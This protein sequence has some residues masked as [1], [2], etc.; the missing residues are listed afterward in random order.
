MPE[1]VPPLQPGHLLVPFAGASDET[2]ASVAQRIA[3]PHLAALLD[4]M[5]LQ[6][7]DRGDAFSL[8]LPHERALAAS[9]GIDRAHAPLADG[10]IPWAARTADRTGVPCAWFTPCHFQA[11]MDQVML[12]PPEA[13]AL[14]DAHARALFDALLPYAREDGITLVYEHATRWRAEGEAL[15]DLPCASLD[16]VAHRRIDAWLPPPSRSPLLTRLQNEA[17]MLF[18]THPVHDERTAQGL[19]GINGFWISGCGVWHGE[20]VP[21]EAAPAVDDRLRAPALRGD[22]KAWEQAWLALDAGPVQTLLTRARGG[23]P[24]R[25]TLCGERHARTWSGPGTV[26]STGWRT[27]LRPSTWARSPAPHP[28]AILLDL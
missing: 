26:R 5:E 17:Q 2:C 15:R 11:G 1:A 9:L 3:L 22:W 4:R 7:E 13:L 25:L 19:P 23:E 6:A 24:V 16:R 14:S 28:G 10:L 27:W 18:Y 20:A 21:P 8:S 12:Q